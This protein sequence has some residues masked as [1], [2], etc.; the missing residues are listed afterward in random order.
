MSQRHQHLVDRKRKQPN[1]VV[2][3]SGRKGRQQTNMHKKKHYEQCYTHGRLC[4]FK[5]TVEKRRRGGGGPML[6]ITAERPWGD[7]TAGNI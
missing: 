6:A 5:N 1:R 7:V 2:Q 3:R 4:S